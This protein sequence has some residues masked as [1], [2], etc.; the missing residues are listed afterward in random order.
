MLPAPMGVRDSEVR[1]AMP[2][3]VKVHILNMDGME[4][5]DA[6]YDEAERIVAGALT[7]GRVVM[8]KRT[9]AIIEKLAPDTEEIL[10]MDFWEGG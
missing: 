2:P 3:T 9:G 5:K 1:G 4:D 6:T 8:D 7:Q 10:I